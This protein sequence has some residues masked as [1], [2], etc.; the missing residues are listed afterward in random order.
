M[1]LPGLTFFRLLSG[2]ILLAGVT[3]LSGGLL[4]AQQKDY[5][6]SP[7]TFRQVQLTD[8]F[9]SSRIE[10]NR[11]ATIPASFARCESTG[12]VSNAYVD[13]LID[14]V[15]RAQEPDR[16][17]YTARTI[18]PLYPHPW[19]GPDRWVKEH[20]LSHEL[21]NSGHMFE[22]ASAHYMATGKRNFLDVAL[23]NADLLVRTFGPGKREVACCCPGGTG[24]LQAI[25]SH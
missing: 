1:H 20:E 24:F 12:R 15:A 13:G 5:P 2:G 7:V 25:H 17:L 6:I 4:R 3:L 22:A 21:Y 19:S 16:Y 23:R 8:S 11:T 18:D 14:T 9:R 10:R